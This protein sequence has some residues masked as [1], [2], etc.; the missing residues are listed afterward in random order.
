MDFGIGGM[1]FYRM[2]K[3]AYPHVSV[4][5][6]S[7]SG[8]IPYG[9]LSGQ[10]LEDRLRAIIAFLM[11]QGL[12]SLVVACNAMS[13]ILDEP[14]LSSYPDFPLWGVIDSTLSYLMERPDLHRLALFG[15]DRTVQSGVYSR[16]LLQAGKELQQ[17][18]AQ[19]LSLLIERGEQAGAD[20]EKEF[21][22]IT[23]AVQDPQA[24][25][26]ACTHY[27]AVSPL[28]SKRFP[29]AEIVDTARCTLDFLQDKLMLQ[30]REGADLFMTSGNPDAMRKASILA[31]GIDPGPVQVLD[32]ELNNIEEGP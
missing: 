3:E 11:G 15:G 9:T 20:F 29:G 23:G 27:T 10:E 5:Y 24:V 19:P 8:Y 7:D 1:S 30:S 26:L 14:F 32:R 21:N 6:F 18:S 25:V 13:T 31:F 4:L 28:F 2:F 22:R 17:R 16:P 12:H